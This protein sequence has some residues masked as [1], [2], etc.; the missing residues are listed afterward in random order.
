MTALPIVET[1][2]GDVSAYI[3]T[4]IISITDGQ[5]FLE[6][7]L[8]FEGQRPAVNVGLSVSRVGGAAQTKAMK[9]AVGT[10]RLDLAQY[11]EMEI[12]TR[13]SSDLDEST[14]EQLSYGQGLVRLLR[15]PQYKPMKLHEQVITLVCAL[16]GITLGIPVGKIL[17]FREELLSHFN[18]EHSYI[19]AEINNTELLSAETR[20]TVLE[21][22][23]Q[24]RDS[25]SENYR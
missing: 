15:Q 9:K 2:A 18:N 3:P 17:A 13:F 20:N 25:V 23:R 5:I 8:F 19:C 4:N 16:G 11:R 1:Q 24:F 14:T 22:A 21:I 10:L 6:S 12:F 7:D